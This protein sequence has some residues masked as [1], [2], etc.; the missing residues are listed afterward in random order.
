MVGYLSADNTVERGLLA[1]APAAPKG[2]LRIS[3]G[4]SCPFM[5]YG[6]PQITNNW[7]AVWS[8]LLTYRDEYYG[9]VIQ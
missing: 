4:G 1:F 6:Y 7:Q 2:L 3:S 9:F 5:D 8:T